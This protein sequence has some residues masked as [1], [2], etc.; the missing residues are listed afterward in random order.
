M[1][2][3]ITGALKKL[4]NA[5]ELVGIYEQ[6]EKYGIIFLIEDGEITGIGREINAD[7]K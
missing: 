6:F 7:R 3:E 4:A 2:Y 1:F 5:V